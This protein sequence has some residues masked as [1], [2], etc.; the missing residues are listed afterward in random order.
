M[1]IYCEK[2]VQRS[3]RVPDPFV[4]FQGRWVVRRLAPDC[5]RIEL[6]SLAKDRDEARLLYS[7]GW[8][9]ANMHFATPQATAK[10]QH[11]LASRRG[12]WLH[13]A[14]KAMLAATRKDLQKWGGGL[15]RFSPPLKP[16]GEPVPV[17]SLL[18]L[19]PPAP[20]RPS[21]R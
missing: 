17:F 21:G 12:R 13:K 3:I 14:S 16:S 20:T 19:W 1:E 2:L 18:L 10:L 4:R 9:T 15:E 8:E 5:S 11:D 6:A 7:M